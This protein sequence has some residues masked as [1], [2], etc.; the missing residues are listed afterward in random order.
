MGNQ[1]VRLQM[2]TETRIALEHLSVEYG[3]LYGGKPHI[4]GLLAQL[5]DGRLELKARNSSKPYL[6][7]APLLKLTFYLPDG[8]K[9][10]FSQVA[11]AISGSGGNVFK[12][13]V[14]TKAGLAQAQVLVALPESSNLSA[15]VTSLQE[16][17]V[18]DV[19][20]FNNEEEILMAINRLNGSDL[21]PVSIFSR[22]NPSEGG[23]NPREQRSLADRVADEIIDR[24]LLFDL[25]CTIGLR[26]IVSNQVGTL[27]TVTR[28]IAEQGF[29]VSSA[30]QEFDAVEGNDIIEL[31]LTLHPLK[32]SNLATE[33]QKINLIEA[34]LLKV[35]A[36]K[37]IQ[38]LGM[39]Y[40]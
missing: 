1:S 7:N 8:L 16:I 40:L 27:F 2:S 4:S 23:L 12:F 36:I 15:L 25:T 32:P 38:R 9:G 22:N 29:S 35:A 24:P 17:K 19:M 5:A 3:C 21:Y 34:I 18:R 20:E 11:S 37:S 6:L 39:D 31:L 14:S 13:D 30:K 10:G 26:L 33:I 28:T